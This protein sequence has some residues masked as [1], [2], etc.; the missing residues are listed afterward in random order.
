MAIAR[1][2]AIYILLLLFLECYIY[3]LCEKEVFTAVIALLFIF[4]FFPFLGFPDWKIVFN[5]FSIIIS[6]N[7]IRLPFLCLAIGLQVR[8]VKCTVKNIAVD[9]SFNQM[10][11]LCALR[12]LEQ[13][14]IIF[15]N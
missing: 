7:F 11:G 12:F 5:V 4:T 14:N 6:L 13:V 10:A 2:N 3:I 1:Y 8:V 15:A 9:I